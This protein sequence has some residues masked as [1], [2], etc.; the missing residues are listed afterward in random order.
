M[1][2]QDKLTNKQTNK[3]EPWASFY[4]STGGK[5]SHFLR[6]KRSVVAWPRCQPWRRQQRA[7]REPPSNLTWLS[8]TLFTA[9]PPPTLHGPVSLRPSHQVAQP[10]EGGGGGSEE[11]GGRGGLGRGQVT[12]GQVRRETI[13]N[14]WI[15]SQEHC[16]NRSW[17]GKKT[18]WVWKSPWVC[19]SFWSRTGSQ[20]QGSA[21]HW[22]VSALY[23]GETSW[24]QPLLRSASIS[25]F[26]KRNK[27]NRLLNGANLGAVGVSIWLCDTNIGP[28]AAGWSWSLET[29]GSTTKVWDANL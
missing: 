7:L 27:M 19:K 4:Q 23:Q 25:R 9:L 13:R 18:S 22:R 26:E 3:A 15:C 10:R 16:L 21:V 2:N 6:T 14:K 29:N 12:Q 20:G 28:S 17:H 24:S 8:F 1:L 11:E 5:R